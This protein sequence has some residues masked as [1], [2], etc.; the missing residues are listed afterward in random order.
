METW[1]VPLGLIQLTIGLSPSSRIMSKWCRRTA[2]ALRWG[3]SRSL[4]PAGRRVAT[5]DEVP[6]RCVHR[7]T[8]FLISSD[9]Q[10]RRQDRAAPADGRAML[11]RASPRVLLFHDETSISPGQG[12][13][14]ARRR[15][16]VPADGERD[17]ARMPNRCRRKGAERRSTVVPSTGSP[18]LPAE[19]APEVAL[20]AVAKTGF[21]SE[22]TAN[23]VSVCRQDIRVDG[24][25]GS[26]TNH[27]TSQN[28][29]LDGSAAGFPARSV[30]GPVIVGDSVVGSG[31][32][33]G[34]RLIAPSDPTIEVDVRRDD[35]PSARQRERRLGR[36]AGRSAP[37]RRPASGPHR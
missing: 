1:P 24:E 19:A 23:A 25:G 26:F 12:R 21:R 16:V 6:I 17:A 10:D 13:T 14:A 8:R 28:Q 5:R 37:R 32:A 22:P 9:A 29:S 20:D 4:I 18:D 15:T 31:N 7:M 36:R 11:G 33:P 35:A 2:A 30:I 34:R 3:W 27:G